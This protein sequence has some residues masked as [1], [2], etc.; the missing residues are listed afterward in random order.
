MK[1]GYIHTF[2]L[3]TGRRERIVAS[4]MQKVAESRLRR[5]RLSAWT[6]GAVAVGALVSLV[7][8]VGYALDSARKSGFL[9]YASLLFSDTATVM[10]SWKAFLFTMADS[11]P[12][13]GA[14]AC[15]GAALILIASVRSFARSAAI[16]SE[17]RF[18]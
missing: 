17:R 1:H 16:L 9:E 14:I 4:V 11:A 18:A 12:I 7:P 5:A 10:Q 6:N 2:S 3:E 8:A 13:L 15:V